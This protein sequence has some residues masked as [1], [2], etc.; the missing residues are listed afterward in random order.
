MRYKATIEARYD[1][2]HYRN[3]TPFSGE[4]NFNAKNMTAA[5]EV[6]ELIMPSYL[7]RD[8]RLS[9]KG[10]LPWTKVED[11]PTSREQFEIGQSG[12]HWS[13]KICLFEELITSTLI[14]RIIGISDTASFGYAF[15][16][17]YIFKQMQRPELDKKIDYNA[18]LRWLNGSRL[19]NTVNE[20]TFNHL[21]DTVL[22]TK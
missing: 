16:D 6:A 20:D 7:I 2:A 15:R 12:E 18:F 17:S 13:W 19:T 14:N 3:F 4:F 21:A 1:K 10:K 11:N 5:K 22:I 9:A 8:M